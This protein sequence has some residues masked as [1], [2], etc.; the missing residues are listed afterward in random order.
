MRI[1]K[2]KEIKT[3]QTSDNLQFVTIAGHDMEI[4]DATSENLK[5][6]HTIYNDDTVSDA[7]NK[8]YYK[9]TDKSTTPT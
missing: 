1:L 8:L 2:K 4:S 3:L 7:D 6:K 9:I 5:L